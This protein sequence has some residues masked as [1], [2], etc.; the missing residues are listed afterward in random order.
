MTRRGVWGLYVLSWCSCLYVNADLGMRRGEVIENWDEWK[1]GDGDD[2]A[3][4]DS[5]QMNEAIFDKG[6]V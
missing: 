1:S 4:D 5:H 6:N 2:M 3:D